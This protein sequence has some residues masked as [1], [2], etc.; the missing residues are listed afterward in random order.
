MES[1]GLLTL[2]ALI[3]AAYRITRLITSDTFPFEKFRLQMHGTWLGKLLIC[4][5]CVSVWIGGGLAVGQGLVGDGWGWQVFI[6]GWALSAA[7]SLLA[8]LVPHSFD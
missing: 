6:G 8:A 5:F 7:V 3:L 4:P 2:I 1:I